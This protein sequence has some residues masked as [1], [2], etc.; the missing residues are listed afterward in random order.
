[1]SVLTKFIKYVSQNILGMIGVSCYI[2]VDTFFISKVQGTNGIAVLN[3]ALPVY[4]LIFAIGSMIGVGSATKYTISSSKNM[5]DKNDYFSNGILFSVLCGIPF[6]LVGIF[7]SKDL[8]ALL[9]GN[10]TIVELGQDYFSIFLVF[11][12]FFM[13]NYVINAFVR[14][15]NDPG[16]AMLGT[17][18]GSI[19]NIIFDYI[20]MFTL[21]F[22]MK[23]AALATAASPI[24][25]SL[26]CSTHF[27]KKSNNIKFV[28]KMSSIKKLISSCVLGI[29]AFIGELSSAVT[30]AVFNF[31]LLGLGG[32]VAVAA[33]G[34][35]A[36]IALVATGI[37]N[38]IAQGSQP[39]F[40]YYYGKN[41][42][43]NI[44]KIFRYGVI[45]SII[46]SVILIAVIFS[47]TNLF[48][49]IFNS[50][51]SKELSEMAF[52][53][54]RLY[55]IGYIFAGINIV[56]AGYMCAIE[57][58]KRAFIV[59]ILRG[60]VLIVLCSIL[61]SR[62]LGINGV[63]CSFTLSEFLTGLVTI[64]Q[65]IKIRKE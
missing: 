51:K 28:F 44:N 25:N 57:E 8:I 39:L 55:F 9:G 1:M 16:R 45:L 11:A 63:W 19:F 17:M 40:S 3:L 59:S 65:I 54:L 27:L 42:K 33:Y 37:Y 30:T 53:G 38:G 24:V 52:A 50:E 35:I 10:S 62:F 21:G 4:G 12:P 34:I 20:F 56:G 23:G 58:G 7:G 36:N 41:E 43:N 49:D 5:D 2:L 60:F 6:V 15:D 64:Y 26:V 18:S 29:S 31:L 48:I 46:F 13:M 32:T 47:N 14:N 22:G 61:L